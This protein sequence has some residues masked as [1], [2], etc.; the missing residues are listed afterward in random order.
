[1]SITFMTCRI[2]SR[3]IRLAAAALAAFAPA[4]HA[5]AARPNLVV[6]ITV[7][8]FRPDYLT[9]FQ[10]QLT[11]G[12]RRLLD[13]G[14]VFLRGYQDHAITETA[15]GHAATMSGRFPV[16]T[17]I[18]FNSEGVND[19]PDADVI[20]APNEPSA[21]PARFHGTTLTDWMRAQDSRMRFLSVSR[22]DRGAILPIGRTKGPVFWWAGSAGTFTTSR[23]YADSLPG[24]VRQF[25]DRHLAQRHAGEAWTLLL[26]D[27]AYT[28]PDSIPAENRG[29]NFTFPHMVPDDSAAAAASAA[30]FPWMDQMILAFALDGVNQLQLGA[31][32]GRT[33]LLAVSLSTTDAVGHAFGP[34]SREMHD[35]VLRLDRA[36][37]VFFDSLFKLRDQRRIIVALTADHGMSPSP[38]MPSPVDAN[39]E[40][41]IVSLRNEFSAFRQQLTARGV[42][43]LAVEFMEGLV[44]VTKPDAFRRARVNVDSAVASFGADAKRVHGVLRADL[45]TDL[46]KMDTVRDDVAR[47]WLHMFVP[48]GPVR[49][50]VTLT[51][52]SYWAPGSQPTHGS[53]HETDARVPVIFYGAGIRPRH[54]SSPV[55]VVDMAPTLAALLQVKPLEATDGRPLAQVVNR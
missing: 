22:K 47:R 8:Q 37:G 53:P 42:D 49:M 48:E 2:S 11:G 55:R 25:N 5:Q 18:A 3:I 23:Y 45:F 28:E 1:M 26:P 30:A 20:G 44:I 7:D 10:G 32:N 15:P 17:G 14:A 46:A 52:F 35:Q 33:D 21:S 36:L 27:S 43:S 54:D 34:D 40:A 29:R 24:W 4:V 31:S 38:R 41:S 39:H 12:L 19:V 51:P 6:F 9:R 50:A 13:S 16:H